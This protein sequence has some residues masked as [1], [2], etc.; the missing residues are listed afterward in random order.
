MRRHLISGKPSIPDPMRY[1]LA[2][3]VAAIV[4]GLIATHFVVAELVSEM[5]NDEV[6]EALRRDARALEYTFIGWF[7]TIV[8]SVTAGVAVGLRKKRLRRV[9]D[10]RAS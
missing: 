5:P 3:F 10:N 1:A 4:I 8:G 6:Y 9:E 2:A 7:L